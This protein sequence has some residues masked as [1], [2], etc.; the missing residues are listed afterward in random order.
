LTHAFNRLK[1][2]RFCRSKRALAI[3]VTFLILFVSTLMLISVTYAF[4][5]DR[6]NSK[7][8]SLKITTAK[9][10]LITLD[11][12]IMAVASQPGSARPFDMSNSGGQLN[13]E[14]SQNVLRINVSDGQEISSTVFNETVGQIRYE[15]PSA[16]AVPTGLFLKGDERSIVNQTGASVT[17]L[18]I[19]RSADGPEIRLSYRPAVSCVVSGEEAGQSVN[20]LRVYVVNL[21]ASD[22]VSLYGEIPFRVSCQ[23]T[24]VTTI[25]FTVSYPLSRLQVT[26]T[27][28]EVNGQVSI[29]ITSTPQGAII[30]VEIVQCV[31]AIERSVR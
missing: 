11:E 15:L 26:A 2:S 28:N 27:L 20:E 7:G 6:V 1:Y 30:H 3:P 17:Q 29:P 9:Q 25:E 24:Q 19:Q 16:E 14:P 5:V 18:G 4:A 23:S 10:N 21:N 13:I 8:Q 12:N 31:V 22:P